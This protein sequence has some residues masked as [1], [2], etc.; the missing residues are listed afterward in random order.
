MRS[1]SRTCNHEVGNR[2]S[3]PTKGRACS[4]LEK[5]LEK[6]G[7]AAGALLVAT[8]TAKANTIV[9]SG[10]VDREIGGGQ[11]LSFSLDGINTDFVLATYADNYDYDYDG[12]G[13]YD[14]GHEGETYLSANAT[15][16]FASSI[17]LASGA[18]IGPSS[19]FQSSTSTTLDYEDEYGYSETYS[20]SCGFD[21][22]DTCY[23][24]NDYGPYYSQNLV[25]P[26]NLSPQYIGLEF[27]VSGQTYYGWAQI[28][29]EVDEGGAQAELYDFAY[30]TTPGQSIDAGETANFTAVPDAPD[31]STLTLLALGAVGLV[32][33]Q[34]RRKAHFHPA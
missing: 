27:T 11:T 8:A 2:K 4:R 22:K 34:R 15:G 32:A 7:I 29:S 19:S 16:G 1:D 25:L 30:D 31:P 9:Y 18:L 20:Y 21:D 17:P 14:F 12:Y 28:G 5:R 10:P 6:Y 24:T 13:D 33:L 26:N 3:E 23:Q